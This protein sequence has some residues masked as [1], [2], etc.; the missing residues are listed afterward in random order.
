MSVELEQLTKKPRCFC[1]IPITDLEKWAYKKFVEGKNTMQLLA[2]VENDYDKELITIIA[3]LDV[4]KEALD[5]ML[6]HES[7]N[8]CNLEMC[9]TRVRDWLLNILDERS[10]D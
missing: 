1:K 4:D 2:D 6:G 10:H 9:R 3:M 5:T 8:T 7:K